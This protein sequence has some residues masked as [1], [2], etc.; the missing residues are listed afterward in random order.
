[1]KNLR[2]LP[3]MDLNRLLLLV[4]TTFILMGCQSLPASYSGSTV[5]E[6]KRIALADSGERSGH[7]V[8]EDLKI[9]FKYVRSQSNLNISGSILFADRL[10]FNFI[11]IDNFHADLMFVDGQGKV[12]ST[13]GINTSAFSESEYPLNFGANLV[14]PSGAVAMAFSYSGRA[15]SGSPRDRRDRESMEFWDH[16]LQK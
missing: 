9:D 15:T 5:P 4:T 6:A 3:G 8:T 11:R 7:Y 12:L 16:P 14:V 2:R 13:Q 1:M 10:K